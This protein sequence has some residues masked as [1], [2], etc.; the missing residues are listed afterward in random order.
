MLVHIIW[1][2]LIETEE[3]CSGWC[4]HWCGSCADVGAC[5]SRADCSSSDHWCGPFQRCE[6]ALWHILSNG[7]AWDMYLFSYVFFNNN[8]TF[9]IM[10]GF[11]QNLNYWTGG[12]ILFCD[13]ASI[14]LILQGLLLSCIVPYL[15]QLFHV[16]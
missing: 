4:C 5:I 1:C 8:W 12:L 14:Q 10:W 3:Q 13:V 11:Y 7:M 6:A 2:T 16:N 15:F 9:G